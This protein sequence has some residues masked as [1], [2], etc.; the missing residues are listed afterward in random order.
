MTFLKVGWDMKHLIQF[1]YFT[2]KRL[3][4]WSQHIIFG[5]DPNKNLPL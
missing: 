5:S 4:T 3:L 2:G 1:H